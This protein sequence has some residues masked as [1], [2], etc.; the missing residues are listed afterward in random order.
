MEAS[1]S[2]HWWLFCHTESIFKVIQKNWYT[3]SGSDGSWAHGGQRLWMIIFL[4]MCL[5]RDIS[6]LSVLYSLKAR[7]RRPWRG[8]RRRRCCPSPWSATPSR[9][10]W[11]EG[12]A[13]M[14][15]KRPQRRRR[16]LWWNDAALIKSF[17]GGTQPTFIKSFIRGLSSDKEQFPWSH[18]KQGIEVRCHTTKSN[19]T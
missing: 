19:F 11:S 14:S 10:A 6:Q 16:H 13:E 12:P 8:L 3:S 4:L 5:S 17:S 15:S 7:V 18:F 1:V 9:P 2:F